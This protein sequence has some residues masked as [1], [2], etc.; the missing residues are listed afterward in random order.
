MYKTIY[1]STYA[2]WGGK[3]QFLQEYKKVY[4]YITI[5]KKI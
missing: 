2:T 1:A 4:N 3:N 5:Q